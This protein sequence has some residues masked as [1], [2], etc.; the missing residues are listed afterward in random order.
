MDQPAKP[1]SNTIRKKKKRKYSITHAWFLCL[2]ST[3]PVQDKSRQRSA[4]FVSITFEVF[5]SLRTNTEYSVE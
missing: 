1:A 2:D 5:N 3:K 4:R